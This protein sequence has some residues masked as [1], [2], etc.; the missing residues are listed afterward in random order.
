MLPIAISFTA[1]IAAASRL[2]LSSKALVGI[3]G[4]CLVAAVALLALGRDRPALLLLLALL[5]VLGALRAASPW[6]ASDHI[7]FQRI[8]SVVSV[9]GRLIEEPVRWAGDRTRLLLDLEAY[10]DGAGRQVA[11]G[12]IQLTIYGETAPLGEGQRIRSEARLHHP[13]GFRNPEAFDYPAALRRSGILLVG[14]GRGDRLVP[15]TAD[16]PPWPV[17]VRRW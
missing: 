8:P 4:G 10:L 12:R 13:I 1:G 16:I 6:L 2:D 3:A 17:R 7:V 9:E 14:S 11:S 5:V 15:L